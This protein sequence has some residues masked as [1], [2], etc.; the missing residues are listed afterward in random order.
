MAKVNLTLALVESAEPGDNRELL[1]Q[2]QEYVD[3]L[4]SR[5]TERAKA[6]LLA[7]LETAE[8]DVVTSLSAQ[9]ADP[10]PPRR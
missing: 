8:E 7:R 3:L 6:H 4:T 1:R 5:Q 9:Q 10:T 2:I